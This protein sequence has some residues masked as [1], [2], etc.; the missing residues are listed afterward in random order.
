MV[1]VVAKAAKERKLEVTVGG[2]VSKLTRELFKGDSELRGLVDYVETR[3][4]IMP[5]EKFIQEEALN[6]ALLL[7]EILLSK[8]AIGP[9]RVLPIVQ[10]R[11]QA[12]KARG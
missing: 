12:I 1:K 8:R 11:K 10:N 9:E 5:V 2:S 4:A 3:K 6:N 7:E